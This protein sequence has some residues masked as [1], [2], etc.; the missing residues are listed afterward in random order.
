MDQGAKQSLTQIPGDILKSCPEMPG[1]KIEQAGMSS[2]GREYGVNIL[3]WDIGMVSC[4]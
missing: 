3:G 4:V 1:A 2:P